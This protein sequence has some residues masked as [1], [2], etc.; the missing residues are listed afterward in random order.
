[1]R[2]NVKSQ[3]WTMTLMT[4]S[5]LK[6][7]PIVLL[8]MMQILGTAGVGR[9]G[10]PELIPLLKHQNESVRS[11]A[12]DELAKIGESAIPYLIPLLKDPDEWFRFYTESTL[13][14]LGYRP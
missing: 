13:A 14:T 6:L 8:A 4:R 9:S 1:M 12:I 2:S 7:I 10:I 3:A 11:T 5:Q